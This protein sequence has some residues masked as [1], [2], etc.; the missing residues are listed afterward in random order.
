[1]SL[2]K[3]GW[4]SIHGP[5]WNVGRTVTAGPAAQKKDIRRLGHRRQVGALVGEPIGFSQRPLRQ[6]IST[7]QGTDISPS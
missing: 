4:L 2:H 5:L 7:L 6:C 3:V 1:M